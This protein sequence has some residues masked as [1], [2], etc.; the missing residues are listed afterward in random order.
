MPFDSHV[1]LG[2]LEW[3]QAE[4]RGKGLRVT[5]EQL[6]DMIDWIPPY[7]EGD[8]T[9]VIQKL[10]DT[11]RVKRRTTPS[12]SD[13]KKAREAVRRRIER[14]ESSLWQ[15]QD[16]Q[17]DLD[18][19]A[20]M[21]PSKIIP[22]IGFPTWDEADTFVRWLFKNGLWDVF[23][24]QLREIVKKYARKRL[25]NHSSSYL[26]L[27]DEWVWAVMNHLF[28]RQ[29]GREVARYMVEQMSL[30]QLKPKYDK[31][32]ETTDIELSIKNSTPEPIIRAAM[33]YLKE[34]GEEL[35]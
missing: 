20:N 18:K 34:H 21:F 1:E 10:G 16:Y 12:F 32:G 27:G 23:E 30:P 29:G 13:Y 26:Q 9:E 25:S 22:G 2:S 3:V 19:L 8:V 24:Q 28:K 33:K 5:I 15:R 7:D 6:D 4:L 31:Y 11:K 17:Q 35:M 14:R